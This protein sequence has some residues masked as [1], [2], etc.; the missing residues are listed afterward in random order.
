M[1][2]GLIGLGRIGAFHA[3]DPD[4]PVGGRRAGRHRCDTGRGRQ[5]VVDSSA[6]PRWPARMS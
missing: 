5:T 4:R 3:G 1:R 2:V 6:P